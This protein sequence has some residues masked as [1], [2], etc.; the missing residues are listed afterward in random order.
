MSIT[1]ILLLA[2]AAEVR[3]YLKLLQDALRIGERAREGEASLGG[4]RK[5]LG[6]ALGGIK[7]DI[8]TN[9]DFQLRWLGL[10]WNDTGMSMPRRFSFRSNSHLSGQLLHATTRNTFAKLTAAPNKDQL[11]LSH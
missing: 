9:V 7:K 3:G 1:L 6:E 5:D 8:E 2:T 4:I 10:R 11:V